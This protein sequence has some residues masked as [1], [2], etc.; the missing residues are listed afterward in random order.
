M[1]PSRITAKEAASIGKA[2]GDPSRMNL[3]TYVASNKELFCG[4]ICEYQ[5]LSGA[6]ISHHLRVLQQAG[7][8]SSKREGQFIYYRA[9]PQR[10]KDYCDY[11]SALRRPSSVRRSPKAM[12]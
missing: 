11:L 10:L 6:T 3:Y 4:Q 5:A 2:L 7:L 12:K 8:I 1:K 9:V